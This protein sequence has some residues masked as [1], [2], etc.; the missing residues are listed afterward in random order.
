MGKSEKDLTGLPKILIVDDIREHLLSMEKLLKDFKIDLFRASSGREAVSLANS[1]EFAL[2]ILDVHMPELD[3]FKTAELIRYFGSSRYSPIIF[4]TASA[5]DEEQIFRGYE[6]GAVDYILRPPNHNIFKSKVKIFL[7]LYQ[8]KSLIEKQ[9]KR[10]EESLNAQKKISANLEIAQKRAEEANKSK[11]IYLANLS[12]EIR[13]PLNSIVGFCQ[14]LQH[15]LREYDLSDE[16]REHLNSIRISGQL[17]NELINNILDL[18]KIEAGKMEIHEEELNLKTLFEG[19]WHVNKAKAFEKGLDYKYTFD[20]D[21]PDMIVSDRTKLNQILMN[22]VS[23]AIKFTPA[24]KKVRLRAILGK[25][26]VLFRVVDNGIGIPPERQKNIFEPFEQAEKTITRDF[27]GTGLGLAVTRETVRLMKGIIDLES[28]PGEKTVFS[29]QIPLKMASSRIREKS[30]DENDRQSYVFS[31]DQIILVAEDNHFNR[32]M[33]KAMLNNLGLEIHTANDGEECVRKALELKPDLILTDINMP[34]M[35][36]VTAAREIHRDSECRDIPIVA[37]SAD[38]FFEQQK[39]AR[40]AG[41]LEYVTKP[42]D[43]GR[44]NSVLSKYLKTVS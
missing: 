43:I 18:S 38:A 34:K 11:S 17:L 8:Q 26:T 29:V 5:I 31:K 44:L 36:G 6:V 22:L 40:D 27:G 10:L 16:I 1:N 32:S 25:G 23:N 19:I 9:R 2:I 24:G 28:V 41:I 12:H 13:S 30:D 3:G 39:A 4:L 33:I 20:P 21:L 35:D 15:S 7:E 37:L 14:I 42:I